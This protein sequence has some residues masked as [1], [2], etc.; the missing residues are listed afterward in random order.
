MELIDTTELKIKLKEVEENYQ[1]NPNEINKVRLGIIY[2]ETALN[3]SFFSKTEFKGYAKKSFDTLS[4]LFNSPNTTKELLPFIASYRASA[5]SLVGAETKKLKLLGE[6]FSLFNDA[7][8]NYS[9]VSYLPEFLRGSVA[10]NLPWFFF[11]KR[12]FAKQDFQSIIDKQDKNSDYA[13]WKIMSFTYWAWTKQRQSKKH[14]T[15]ALEY[16]DKAIAL[17]P[18]YR[19]GRQKAEKLKTTLTK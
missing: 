11:T 15:Q 18:N 9:S 4:E 2:H 16:L 19:A 12:K 13:N 8:K 17:D 7:V 5:L 6:A 10:E 1:Q 3:L 14:R